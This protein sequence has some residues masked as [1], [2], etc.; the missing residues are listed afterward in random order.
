MD[1]EGAGSGGPSG[2]EE[3]RRTGG[4][5]GKPLA[6]E[7]ASRVLWLYCSI[8]MNLL[9]Q[10]KIRV[11]FLHINISFTR[12]KQDGTYFSFSSLVFQT[13]T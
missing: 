5:D 7:Q 10:I 3:L 11:T 6:K 1:R 2:W 8:S 4:E 12:T 9:N 13:V